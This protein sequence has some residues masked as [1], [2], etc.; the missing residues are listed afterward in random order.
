MEYLVIFNSLVSVSVVCYLTYKK[1]P[2]YISVN[3]TFWCKKTSSITLWMYTR[4]GKYG[5]SSKGLLTI[6]VRNRK[7]LNEW[8]SE[9]FSSGEYKKYR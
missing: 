4:R 8:D 6:P 7:K 3:K 5:S 1:F 9:M 2:F